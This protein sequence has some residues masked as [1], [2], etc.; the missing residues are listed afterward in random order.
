[1]NLEMLMWA[2]KATGNPDEARKF[3]EIGIKHSNQ[4]MVNHLRND[5][6]SYHLVEYDAANGDVLKR[7]TFQGWSNNS[8][9][10]RG[11]GWGIYGFTMMYRETGDPAYLET[12]ENMVNAY[13]NHPRLP[14]DK[15]PRWD[16]DA[17]QPGYN[18]AFSRND[19]STVEYRDASAGALVASALFELYTLTNKSQS[20]N[21][22]IDM[23]H[24][25]AST[26]YLAAETTNLGFLLKHCVGNF[27]SGS[28]VDVPLI[29]AD[30]YFLE[31]LLRYQS[32]IKN[33]TA[34]VEG[35]ATLPL[36]SVYCRNKTLVIENSYANLAIH[37]YNT[38]GIEVC[39]HPPC[40]YATIELP[41]KGVYIVR[42]GRLRIR[43]L[44]K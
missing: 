37:V 27:P 22:A 9:W 35:V 21:E 1:M 3:R 40:R 41:Q 2:S 31:A 5:Y 15:I 16:F 39:N 23:I 25:L 24:S 26:E 4:T 7:V 43:I 34:A 36:P 12:A 10:A 18:K 20:L 28:E 29:Y 33:M 13:L 42:T 6:T 30:Y 17:G 11:Q 14:E 38:Q 32:I 44:I 19:F 8:M